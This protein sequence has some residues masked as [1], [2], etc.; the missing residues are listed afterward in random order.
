MYEHV[1]DLFRQA[2]M[3]FA[4]VATGLGPEA[5]PARRAYEKVG[6]KPLVESV[7]Y[8]QELTSG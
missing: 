4:D 3:R 7:R 6:F 2:G 8:F 5:A 1:L